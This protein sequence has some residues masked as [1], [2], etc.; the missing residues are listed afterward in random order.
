ELSEEDISFLR[1]FALKIEKHMTNDTFEACRFAFPEAH[2]SPFKI[3]KAR[4]EFLAEFQPRVYDCC[5]SS[6][7]C[8]VG[9]HADID[10]CP[11]CKEPRF[12]AQK[13]PR[14][15]FTYVPLIPRLL[16]YFRNPDFAAKL[17]YRSEYVPSAGI[18]KDYTDSRHY[19]RLR[20]SDVTLNGCPQLYK[21]FSDT[22]DIAL[23]LS[24]DG[25]CPFR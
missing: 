24:T 20:Q 16:A 5:V 13:K 7:C 18:M 21:F 17:D 23:G 4:A 25:F 15:R 11:Y 9:P 6:C 1:H 19:Q 2:I 12:N 10:R 8:Y 14:K 3:T 22:R